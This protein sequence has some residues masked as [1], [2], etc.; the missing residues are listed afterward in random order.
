M[1]IFKISG[2]QIEFSMEGMDNQL[3]QV[4]LLFISHTFLIGPQ[5]YDIIN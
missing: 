5:I 4:D 1:A 3:F 2:L